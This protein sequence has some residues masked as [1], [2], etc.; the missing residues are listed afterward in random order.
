MEVRCFLYSCILLLGL[1]GE[2]VSAQTFRRIKNVRELEDGAHYVLAGYCAAH[3]DSL[4]VMAS[5]DKTGTGKKNRA[6]RKLALDRNGRIHINDGG[7]AIFELSVEGKAY[8]FRD[9]V[10]DAW[11]AYTTGR[12]QEYA[13]LLTLTDEE[14]TRLPAKP[15]NK[16]SNRF[17]II[18]SA[19]AR[20]SKTPLYTKEDIFTSVSSKKQFGL[21]PVGGVSFK[22]CEQDV[23]DSLFIYKEVQSPTLERRED[24]DWTFKGDWLADSLFALDYAQARRIDFTE[25][26]LPQGKSM[27]GDGKMPK[28][29]VWTYVRKGEAGRL[30][31]GWPNVV[32]IDRKD[33]DIQGNAVT[34]MVGCGSC[35]LGPKYSFTVPEETGIVWY[36]KAE[37]D[38]GWLTV[39]L[40]YAV[41]KVAWE[42]ADGETITSERLCFEE[43]TGDGAV[44]REMEADE[45]WQAGMPYLWRPSE[46]RESV[47]CF[48]G[49]DTVVQPQES[50]VETT[51]GFYAV[52]GRYDI[53][54]DGKTVFLLDDSGTRFVRAAAGSWV[55]PGRGY[56]VYTGT[57]FHSVR[58]IENE[59]PAGAEGIGTRMGGCLLPVYGTD[60]I[61]RGEIC[62]GGHIPEEWP[63]GMYITPFGKMI[64]K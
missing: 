25:I 6:A 35:T 51:D 19:S 26:A 61:K 23:G 20:L 54:D 22:L 39:G 3:P 2:V 33:E 55:A 62:P 17:E 48:Y 45:A 37:N 34:R 30:P 7:T 21:M 8:A 40:P 38:G 28:G 59:L 64:K 53:K 16:Y 49:E 10:L 12:V 36:R 11:L 24:G 27:V 58:L 63:E 41:K 18:P 42:D 9:I 1:G 50:D 15:N 46:P 47:V 4:Y 60:G 13:S 14:L 56:L 31:E 43:I 32:E 29:Y 52:F 44:F 57:A 5:Q